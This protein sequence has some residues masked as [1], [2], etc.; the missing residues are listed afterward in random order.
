MFQAKQ[1][2]TPLSKWWVS[3]N[4]EKVEA[5]L[6][7]RLPQQWFPGFEPDLTRDIPTPHRNGKGAQKQKA[8]RQALGGNKGRR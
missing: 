7:T 6:D 3:Q 4:L 1:T 2:A 5:V 8:R